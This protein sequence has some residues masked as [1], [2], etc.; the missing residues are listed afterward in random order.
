MVRQM[1]EEG[2]LSRCLRAGAVPA[3]QCRAREVVVK[4]L[5]KAWREMFLG[6]AVLGVVN[7]LWDGPSLISSGQGCM[8][9]LVYL[10]AIL[11]PLALAGTLH[12]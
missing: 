11:S 10:P 4:L 8:D 3:G 7:S 9:S 12:V 1:G 5:Q 6:G 2:G